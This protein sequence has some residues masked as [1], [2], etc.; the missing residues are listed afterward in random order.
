MLSIILPVIVF[1]VSNQYFKELPTLILPSP[2]E[3]TISESLAIL[4][5]F[6]DYKTSFLKNNFRF[7]FFDVF[8]TGRKYMLFVF[9]SPK[10]P[11]TFFENLFSNLSFGPIIPNA[12]F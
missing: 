11:Q 10:F 3:R 1:Y 9:T 7:S 8:K 2:E 4:F 12:S 6:P 5:L